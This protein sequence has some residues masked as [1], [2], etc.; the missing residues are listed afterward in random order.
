MSTDARCYTDQ[1]VTVGD[2]D[3]TR[4]VGLYE[5]IRRAKSEEDVYG[6]SEVFQAN[7]WKRVFRRMRL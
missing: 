7:R 3:E 4:H 6:N 2:L 1:W 5:T